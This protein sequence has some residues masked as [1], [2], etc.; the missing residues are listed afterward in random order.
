LAIH[1]NWPEQH[2]SHFRRVKW[3]GLVRWI[4]PSEV[5]ATLVWAG[6]VGC[7]G[8]LTAILFREAIQAVLWCWTGRTGSLEFVAAQLT[9]WQRLIIPAAGGLL[10]G[11][12]LHFGA[13]F[14][15]GHRSSDYME[16]VALHRGVLSLRQN[17]SKAVS[18]LLTIGSGG[19]I[20]REGAM[21]QLSATL[22]SW[23]GQRR[24]LSTPRLRLVVACGA[25]AGIAAVYNVTIAGALFVAEIVLGSIAMES[26]GPL[27][28]AAVASSLVS[29]YV[30]GEQPYFSSPPFSLAA[31]EELLP[32]L[33]MALILGAAARGYI[34]LLRRT[35]DLLTALVPNVHWRLALGGLV[36]GA[37]AIP[38]PEVW[39]NGR[40]MVNLALQNP[41]PWRVLAA[42]LVCKVLAVAVTTGSGAV[43]GVFTPTMF[44]GAMLGCLSGHAVQ[45]WWPG[46]SAGPQAYALVGM[47]GF[48]TAATRAPLLSMLML[49]EMTLDYGMVLPMMVVCVTAY[50]TARAFHSD[51]IYSESL[52]RKQPAATHAQVSALRVRD[53][54][55]PVPVTAQE[56]TPFPEIV[57]LF[58]NAPFRHL[59]V[60]SLQNQLRGV[61]S[62]RDVENHLQR[63]GSSDWLTAAGLMRT[64]IEVVVPEA[65]L[66]EA[67]EAFRRYSGERLPVVNDLQERVLRGLVSKTDLLLTL[68]HGLHGGPLTT[69]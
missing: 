64:E 1:T 8:G 57:R 16:A 48:L 42:I 39:G 37:L 45:A 68:A 46:P 7:L 63:E 36:V 53:L 23:L 25:A 52:R 28:V 34:R 67:L 55:K 31:P 4:H 26:L 29:R 47:A 50:Y 59:L 60:V 9:W 30:G 51:S 10:A 21:V 33:I 15:R 3:Y 49:F 6:I 44:T 38:F 24:H 20:G 17:L 65:T 66:G 22:A 19:S 14:G 35:E 56:N 2:K 41:W 43:G 54:M 13:R 61:I 18:S 58:S 5:Q 32:F 12:V 11:L 27:L 69:V 40:T 62:L